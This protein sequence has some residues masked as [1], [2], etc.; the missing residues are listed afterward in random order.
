MKQTGGAPLLRSLAVSTQLA[1]ETACLACE[2]KGSDGWWALLQPGR[3]I[4]GLRADIIWKHHGQP[5][6]SVH[7]LRNP[8]ETSSTS[9]CSRC[10]LRKM[11]LDPC[12]GEWRLIGNAVRM[13]D[14]TIVSSYCSYCTAPPTSFVNCLCHYS[15]YCRVHHFFSRVTNFLCLI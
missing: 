10:P 1:R 8:L 9:R 4:S 13:A 14:F 15:C 5:M 12:G 11:L 7:N 6:F 2:N 3:A